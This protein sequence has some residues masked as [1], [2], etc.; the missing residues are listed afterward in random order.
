MFLLF[1]DIGDSFIHHS[2]AENDAHSAKEWLRTHSGKNLLADAKARKF[3]EIENKSADHYLKILSIIGNNSDPHEVW[4]TLDQE[5]LL[6]LMNKSNRYKN[7]LTIKICNATS[8]N[9]VLNI[10][11]DSS[12]DIQAT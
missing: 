12:L 8:T 6:P 5:R 11:Y 3:I 1:K 2:N 4:L 10:E 7:N 9:D